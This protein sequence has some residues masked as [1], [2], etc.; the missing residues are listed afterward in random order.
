MVKGGKVKD[1]K[2]EEV[3]ESAEE[4]LNS[5]AEIEKDLPS[6][7]ETYYLQDVLNILREDGK[8]IPKEEL[9]NFR[10]NFLENMPER[11]DDG[12]L[13]VEVAKWTE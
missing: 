3:K 12:S 9:E 6:E 8:T 11:V 5:F 2:W 7:G 1:K 10:K 13:K 4:I